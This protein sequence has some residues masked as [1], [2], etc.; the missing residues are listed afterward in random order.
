VVLEEQN[1]NDHNE[2]EP[3]VEPA[4]DDIQVN[5]GTFQR[6]IFF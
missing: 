5:R 2:N 1:E 4:N 6:L 3:E